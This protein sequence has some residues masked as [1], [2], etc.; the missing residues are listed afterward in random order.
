MTAHG[1][2]PLRILVCT[3][4]DL[5]GAMVLNQILPQLVGDQVMVLLSDKTR[6][7]ENAVPELAEIKFLER[8][9]PIDTIFPLIDATGDDSCHHATFDGLSRRHGIP[10]QVIADINGPEGE[11]LVR[12]FAPDIILSARFSLIFKP[13]IF[14]IPPLGTYNVHPGALPRY[15]GLFAPFRCMLEGGDRIGCTL[16]KVDHGIDTGPIAGIGWITIDPARS[17]L[18]HVTQT[19]RPGL[20]LFFQ[21]LAGLRDGRQPALTQQDRSQ[22]AYGS[23]P[24]AAS[25]KEF[26]AKGF[27]IFDPKD[28]LEELRSFVPEALHAQIDH[29]AHTAATGVGASC[30][31]GHA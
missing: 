24:G 2:N 31:C 15:A 18:W 27:S 8:D 22:R 16:H 14:E 5:A 30:C 25:F 1:R 29:L 17:L 20:E 12:S 21:V 4:R 19:Y 13:N 6:A 3:K 10:I 9:L 28:Y 11:D 26:A 23:L 7:V